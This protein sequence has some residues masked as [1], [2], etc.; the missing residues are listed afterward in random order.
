MI[1][2]VKERNVRLH[3]LKSA[4]ALGLFVASGVMVPA[5]AA[6]NVWT[7][8]DLGAE[9]DWSLGHTPANGDDVLIALPSDK[10]DEW[11][12]YN[13]KTTTLGSAALASFTLRHDGTVKP[14]P[15]NPV[16][17]PDVTFDLPNSSMLQVSGKLA[18]GSGTMSFLAPKGTVYFEAADPFSGFT[19]DVVFSNKYTQFTKS[20]TVGAAG[21]KVTFY[22][23]SA[24]QKTPFTS[25]SEVLLSFPG[26]VDIFQN[27]AKTNETRFS[28]GG[29]TTFDGPVAIKGQTQSFY[30]EGGPLTFTG[31]VQSDSPSNVSVFFGPQNR[32]SITNKI[33]SGAVDVSGVFYVCNS[34]MRLAVP[35]K[36]QK[37]I[38][39]YYN[40]ALVCEADNLF[41]NVPDGIEIGVGWAAVTADIVLKGTRQKFNAINLLNQTT[42][43]FV[44]E[45]ASTLEN[46]DA[47]SRT[48]SGGLKGDLSVVHSGSGTWTL[49]GAENDMNGV[50]KVTDGTVKLTAAARFPNISAIEVSGN[51]RLEVADAASLPPTLTILRVTGNG[52]LVLP[53]DLDLTVGRV[54]FGSLGLEPDE[55]SFSSYP[56]QVTGGGRLT[57]TE[58]PIPEPG[59]TFTWTGAGAD[60]AIETPANWDKPP[61]FNRNAQLVFGTSAKTAVTVNSDVKA[62][63]LTFTG[64]AD[65]VVSAGNANGKLSVFKTL[66]T[67]ASGRTVTISAPIEVSRN[68]GEWNVA[69][70][71]TL[72]LDGAISGGLVD[73]EIWQRGAGVMKLAG[74]NRNLLSRLVVTN[75]MTWAQHEWALGSD[76]RP[77]MFYGDANAA[78]YDAR[79][80]STKSRYLRF[81]PETRAVTRLGRATPLVMTNYTPVAFC[82]YPG[83]LV[84]N[85]TKSDGTGAVNPGYTVVFAKPLR[86]IPGGHT[87]NLLL[88]YWYSTLTLDGGF[89]ADVED[90][91]V[92]TADGGTL[93]LN[94]PLVGGK[95]SLVGVSTDKMRLGASGEA[96]LDA[97]NLMYY[98]TKVIRDDLFAD[99]ATPPILQLGVSWSSNTAEFDLDGHD[100]TFRHLETMNPNV[101]YS[102]SSPV[103]KPATVHLTDDAGW[104]GARVDVI[105]TGEAGL[106][107]TGSGGQRLDRPSTTA[108]PLVVEEGAV[109]FVNSGAWLGSTNVTVRGTGT[110]QVMYKTAGRVFSADAATSQVSLFVEG[111]GKLD[112]GGAG[113]KANADAGLALGTEIVKRLYVNGQGMPAGEYTKANCSF[114]KSGALR[115]LRNTGLGLTVIVR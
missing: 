65:Y 113:C 7:S 101:S 55:Y 99:S 16:N 71:T 54:V 80:K 61:T 70:E 37:V 82:G 42:A 10:T 91:V 67:T 79:G 83:L 26:A 62:Y 53:D 36:A 114:V 25:D 85:K 34:T 69:S 23:S 27:A 109:L 14:R 52:K 73:Y 93:N 6:T 72:Q 48:Y 39:G 17:A 45:G 58:E 41:D 30:F 107:K 60:N 87:G 92:F 38:A 13:P 18:N 22:L 68:D 24:D 19:G 111:D 76:Q 43:K 28:F 3:G 66:A 100:A 106:V 50:L 86:K 46:A 105:F 115:V 15:W 8:G 1:E 81:D 49:S 98:G 20:A 51:G 35:V 32:S 89:Q 57:V 96:A 2:V 102:I 94:G 5:A 64:D 63:S 104:S 110:I 112:L 78:E 4:L 97:L 56:D 90:P 44:G 47:T 11:F 95:I 88:T 12:Q 9:T 103:G 59:E 84:P 29:A 31:G 75:G 40:L 74:D 77:F 108:A 21:R 33:V